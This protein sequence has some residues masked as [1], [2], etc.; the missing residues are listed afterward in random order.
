MHSRLAVHVATPR[1]PPA[2]CRS[3]HSATG[4]SAQRE[5]V[6]RHSRKGGCC[7]EMLALVLSGPA[8]RPHGLQLNQQQC[9]PCAAWPARRPQTLPPQPAVSTPAKGVSRRGGVALPPVPGCRELAH[10]VAAPPP[11][12]AGNKHCDTQQPKPEEERDVEVRA[13]AQQT[14][15]MAHKP[16]SL[17]PHKVTPHPDG[18]PPQLLPYP[19]PQGM[20]LHC[21]LTQG[22]DAESDCRSLPSPSHH[23]HPWPSPHQPPA[24]QDT[25]HPPLIRYPGMKHPPQYPALPGELRGCPSSPSCSR[26]ALAPL[27]TI[28]PQ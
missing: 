19:C 26:C 17:S 4:H 6:L 20:A 3:L 23:Y 9:G 25:S 7:R 14:W 18:L 5:M 28:F 16:F 24:V 8:N 13:A 21:K 15:D 1:T 11:W 2:L 22:L 27:S 12:S 10:R